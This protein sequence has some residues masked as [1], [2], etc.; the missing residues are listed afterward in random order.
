[1]RAEKGAPRPTGCGRKRDSTGGRGH[2]SD[3]ETMGRSEEEDDDGVGSSS[4]KPA[5]FTADRH[6]C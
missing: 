5:A 1:M 6:A 4:S 3:W 2:S